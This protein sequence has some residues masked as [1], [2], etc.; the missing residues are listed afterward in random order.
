[1]PESQPIGGPD[2]PPLLEL[3]P[4]VLAGHAAA[5][6][7]LYDLFAPRLLRR[8]RHRFGAH[9]GLDPE[10]L[11]QDTFV[12]LL[13]RD[14]EVLHRFVER[15]AEPS[16]ADLE[17]FLWSAACGIVSNRKRSVIRHPSSQ[18]EEERELGSYR[19]EETFTLARDALSRLANCLRDS[20]EKFFLYFQMRYVDGFE[21]AEIAQATGWSMKKTYKLKQ[22]LDQAVER[23]AQVLGLGGQEKKR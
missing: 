14:G 19:G 10:D 4:R 13:G 16:P 3:L 17:R 9:P 18:I 1:M 8:L 21:P 7:T 5:I 6:G 11:L 23:C 12:Y 2:G 15:H 22:A 20:G